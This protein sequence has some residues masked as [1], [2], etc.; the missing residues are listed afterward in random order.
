[1]DAL[2]QYT[3]RM[4]FDTLFNQIC[5]DLGKNGDVKEISSQFS[6][7]ATDCERISFVLG[8]EKVKAALQE[9]ITI[10][11]QEISRNG[12]SQDLSTS[13][14]IEGNAYYKKKLNSKALNSYNRSLLVGEGEAVAL[15]YANRSAVFYDT[16]DWLHSLRDIQL[17]FDQGYPRH[18]EHKL[19][20][21]QGNCWLKLGNASRAFLSFSTA[22][23]LLNSSSS[24]SPPQDKISSIVAKL[25]NLGDVIFEVTES[26][27]VKR[28]EQDVIKTRRSAPEL[29]RARNNLLPCASTSIELAD[30][31]GRGRCLIATEDLKLGNVAC[32]VIVK[33]HQ[34]FGRLLAT[35]QAACNRVPC[36]PCLTCER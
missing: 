6:S 13:H 8:L 28:I 7:C 16:A 22:K 24:E 21:R 4:D 9:R 11:K 15:A 30:S 23:D 17:A 36:V 35:S 20:E 14:R 32:Y 25:E 27:N 18:L 33:S 29:N 2:Q 3:S 26:M 31:P 12:K 5:S 10:T 19:R 34:V 1:M